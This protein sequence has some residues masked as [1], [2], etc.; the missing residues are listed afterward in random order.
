MVNDDGDVRRE[1]HAPELR[2]WLSTETVSWLQFETEDDV[3]ISPS[4]LSR[5]H[6]VDIVVAGG[7]GISLLQY[8]SHPSLFAVESVDDNTMRGSGWVLMSTVPICSDQWDGPS[9]LEMARYCKMIDAE[10]SIHYFQSVVLRVDC[11]FVAHVQNLPDGS[12]EVA[13]LVVDTAARESTPVGNLVM[14]RRCEFC[15]IRSHA[16]ECTPALKER[17]QLELMK[18]RFKDFSKCSGD[19][20]PQKKHAT[21]EETVFYSKALME[22]VWMADMGPAG[23]IHFE[24][25]FIFDGERLQA[26]RDYVQAQRFDKLKPKGRNFPSKLSRDGQ[27]NSQYSC[28]HCKRPFNRKYDL[29]RHVESVHENRKPFQCQICSF[30]FS[31]RTHLKEH[32]LTFHEKGKLVCEI[33]QKSFGSASRLRRHRENVHFNIHQHVCEYC[34]KSYKERSHMTKHRESCSFNPFKM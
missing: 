3:P 16:C 23:K 5:T 22:G 20:F 10:G 2:E 32:T 8:L 14:E 27:R 28:T 26:C 6:V 33:C 13:L 30:S 12:L 25:K 4:W 29:R 24:L 15:A 34:E 11:I 21:M 18:Q 17:H 7:E 19:S 1:F 31:Q 9:S